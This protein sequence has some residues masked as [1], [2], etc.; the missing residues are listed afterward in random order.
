[1][2]YCCLCIIALIAFSSCKKNKH[3]I[4][5]KGTLLQSSSNPVSV[6]K[7][8]LSFYQGGNSSLPI[9]ISTSSASDSFKTDAMGNFNCNFT[10]GSGIFIIFTTTNKAAIT[11]S[12]VTSNGIRSIWTDLAAVDTNVGN[13]YLYKLVHTAIIEIDPEHDISPA[14]TIS[15]VV[16]ALTGVHTKLLTGLTIAANNPTAVDTVQD[17]I[18]TNFSFTTKQYTNT[19]YMVRNG[20][21]NYDHIPEFMGDED[22]KTYTIPVF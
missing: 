7:Y 1:M 10:E 20:I 4:T 2:R 17:V 8:V 21:Y 12:G 22:K 5:I 9:A 16:P 14:D 6:S 15:E 3:S 19:V 11:V 18:F 13:I